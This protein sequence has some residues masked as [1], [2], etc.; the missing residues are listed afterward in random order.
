MTTSATHRQ[1]TGVPSVESADALARL[2]DLMAEQLAPRI[3]AEL[4]DAFPEEHA[5]AEPWRL[6]DVADA[7]AR[8]G[9]STRW[10][11]E[12][13]KRGQL[14][15]VRLDGGPLAFQ[16]EDVQAFARARRISAGEPTALA[17]RL[18]NVRNPAP[19][20]RSVRRERATDQE[21]GTRC[22][23]AGAT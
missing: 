11:R 15:F 13:A 17:P 7:A 19:P 12:Q 9:R 22:A 3:A 2:L 8:F 20:A 14:P 21:V 16:L 1:G 23:S 18:Q 6:L 4:A 10:V 5:E